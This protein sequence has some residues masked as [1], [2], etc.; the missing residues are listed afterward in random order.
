M[1]KKSNKKSN[2]ILQTERPQPEDV[3][4]Q[5]KT[6]FGFD[7]DEDTSEVNNGEPEISVFRP[8]RQGLRKVLGDLEADI[9]EYVWENSA[10]GST[11]LTVRDVYEAFRLQRVIAY[12]TVMSTMARLARKRLLHAHKVEAAFVYSPSLSKEAFIDNFVSRILEDLLISF[13]GNTEIQLQRLATTD[14]QERIDSL[15]NKV[16]NLREKAA[17]N[18]SAPTDRAVTDE[19]GNKRRPSS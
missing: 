9:M 19:A 3:E 14:S 10:A 5:T 12:T 18:H 15:K 16:A 7:Q 1:A 8:N 17:A 4:N 13:S 6:D 11:G 2:K